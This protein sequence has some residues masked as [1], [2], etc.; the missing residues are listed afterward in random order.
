[1]RSC[2][3]AVWRAGGLAVWSLFLGT[4]AAAQSQ[5]DSVT[6]S[7]DPPRLPREFRGVWVASVSNIDW[8]SAPGL[9]VEQQK[10]EL[11][12]ILD[13]AKRLRLNTIILQVRP[14]ADALYQSSL[15]PWSYYLTGEQGRAPEPFY[16]PLAFAITEAHQRGLELHAWFNPYR[17]QH[18]SNRGPIS[19]KHISKT[20][21]DLVRAYGPYLWL[22]PGDLE[23]RELSLRVITDVVQRYDVDGVHIDDY[24]YPYQERDAQRRL[25]QFPDEPSWRRYREGGGSKGRDDWRRENIDL[26]VRDLYARVKAIKPEVKVGISPFGIWRPGHPK[27]VFG[28]DAYVAIFADAR[29]WLR[30]GWADYFV[31]QLYWRAQ[32]PQQPYTD[33]LGWWV[34]QNR[35]DRHMLAG[36]APYRVLSDNQNWPVQE[37]VE[38]IRLTRAQPGAAG[39][40]HFSMNSL[41]RNRGGLVDT[42]ASGPY[43][44]D[45]LVPASPWLDDRAPAAPLIQVEPHPLLRATLVMHPGAGE[46]AFLFVVR[47][48]FGEKWFAEV[49][50]ADQRSYLLL[51]GE[52]ALLPDE[53]AVSAVDR[54]GNESALARVLIDR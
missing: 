47:L 37:I 34:E 46:A 54:S 51:R 22:D 24:F 9:P 26:F 38:Q 29:K 44:Y 16:D 27:T 35:K 3:L 40:V 28:M 25:I 53:V 8:P 10:A 30:E 4:A 7:F 18:S 52:P 50:A 33:L 11:I 41:L 13:A 31:P 14:A 43:G 1:M 20:R 6:S 5:F 23:V 36:N 2:G 49:V 39:N 32:A 21:P 15:E 42:L 19:E 12:E 17:A 45:A 48:R